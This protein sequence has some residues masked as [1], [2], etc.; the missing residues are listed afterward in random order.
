MEI[1]SC[2]R[3]GPLVR[4]LQVYSDADERIL[5]VSVQR[6]CAVIRFCQP[7]RSLVQFAQLYGAK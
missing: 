1:T 3:T 4:A 7:N 6:W 5:L 2:I